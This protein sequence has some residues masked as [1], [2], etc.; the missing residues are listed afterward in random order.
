MLK[1]EKKNPINSIVQSIVSSHL[2]SD[3]YNNIMIYCDTGIPFLQEI[4]FDYSS[5]GK[6]PCRNNVSAVIENLK[7]PKRCCRLKR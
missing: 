3:L 1:T 6:T 5:I 2:V 4:R 7:Y